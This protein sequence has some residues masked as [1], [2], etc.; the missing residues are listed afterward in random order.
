LSEIS[1]SSIECGGHSHSHPQL[2]TLAPAEAAREIV[3]SKRLLE[4][5]LGQNI[6]SFAYPFGYHTAGLRR[7]VQEA[8]YRSACAVKY[9][10]S[11]ERTDPFA[12]ARLMV[13]SD[14]DVDALAAMLDARSSLTITTVYSR[15]RT[16]LWQLARRSSA[17]MTH[18][19]QGGLFAR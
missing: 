14:T 1:T 7:Q 13:K 19:L 6:S 4:D 16:P 5:H 3:Q 2:D 15:A 12:L 9:A 8:G 11:S 17:V 10:M 18:H